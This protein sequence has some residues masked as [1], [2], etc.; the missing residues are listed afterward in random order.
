MRK[1]GVVLFFLIMATLFK[2]GPV[3]ASDGSEIRESTIYARSFE[4]FLEF[5]T[6][7]INLLGESKA[8]I[9]LFTDYLTDGEIASSLYL[10]KY[11]KIDVNIVLGRKRAGSYMSRL[12][13]LKEQNISVFIKNDAFNYS[14]PSG[15]LIDE[16]LFN[17]NCP[18]DFM[19]MKKP[20]KIKLASDYETAVFMTAMSK[21]VKNSTEKRRDKSKKPNNKII[22]EKTGKNN[23]VE[24]NADPKPYNYD[25]SK[26]ASKTAPEGAPK[27]LPKVLKYEI[28]SSNKESRGITDSND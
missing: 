2:V 18:L 25:L 22:S 8:R 1:R 9:W 6:E 23:L 17:I 12:S 26:T 14:Y 16:K 13:F 10:A 21:I 11:R 4:S 28:K 19:S 5:R 20:Y 27:I 3:N 7:L 24:K 15:I